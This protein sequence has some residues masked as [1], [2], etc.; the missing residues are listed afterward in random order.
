MNSPT[1]MQNTRTWNDAQ[2][3]VSKWLG[4]SDEWNPNN[5]HAASSCFRHMVMG[6]P[7]QDM[8]KDFYGGISHPSS[9]LRSRSGLAVPGP[10]RLLDHV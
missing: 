4:S 3:D 9:S 2:N 6:Y 7:G 10:S 1:R 5:P 8:D